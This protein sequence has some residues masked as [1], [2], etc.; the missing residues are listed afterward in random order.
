MW[1]SCD[2][3]MKAEDVM[4]APGTVVMSDNRSA[5]T[6]LFIRIVQRGAEADN[7]VA[8]RPTRSAG[9]ADTVAEAVA[10]IALEVFE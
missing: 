2:S 5:R 6:E 3:L 1:N 9:V 8:K 4:Q 7:L 10:E